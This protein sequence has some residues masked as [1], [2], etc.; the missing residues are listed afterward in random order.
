MTFSILAQATTAPPAGGVG[1]T[2][3]WL[4][5]GIVLLGVALALFFVEVFLP[6]GGLIGILAGVAAVFGIVL[7]FRVDTTL[8]LIT[9]AVVLLALPFLVAF[10]LKMWPDTPFGKWVMLR[11]E[12]DT[13]SDDDEHP[14]PV[15]HPDRPRLALGDTGKSLT[16][17]RPVGTCLLNGRREECLAQAGTIPAGVEV[18]VVVLDGNEV[19]VKPR[20]P[21]GGAS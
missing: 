13:V 20:S 21:V 7:L 8:G 12:Q 5:W 16:P 11:D 3:Q 17:L 4:V 1:G 10:G 9:A 19:Y 14:A 18:Q 15:V 6:S 2:G